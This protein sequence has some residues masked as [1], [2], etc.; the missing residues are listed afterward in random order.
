MIQPITDW[1]FVVED[2]R[3]GAVSTHH[4]SR[5][6]L[7]AASDL[8]VTQDLLDH[9]AYVEGGHIVEE[10]RDC[11]FNKPLKVWTILVKWMGLGEIENTWEPLPNLLED[12]PH[13]VRAFVRDHMGKSKNALDMARQCP[14]SNAA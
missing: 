7:F 8:M 14:L 11:K 12:V 5:L 10:L 3:D 6:K 1:I 9:I 13:L 4:I 2:L